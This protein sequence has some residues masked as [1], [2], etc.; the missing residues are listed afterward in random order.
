[1]QGSGVRVSSRAI[2]R[3]GLLTPSHEELDSVSKVF[4]VNMVVSARHPDAMRF[5]HHVG[6]AATFGWLKPIRGQFNP[7]PERIAEIDRVH[8]PAIDRTGMRDATPT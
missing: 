2:R 8:E 5:D 4:L 7:E 3:Q 6:V 1:M